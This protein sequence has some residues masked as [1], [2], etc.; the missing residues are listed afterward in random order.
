[1][2][3][4]GLGLPKISLKYQFPLLIKLLPAILEGLFLSY[5][6]PCPLS[7]GS[8]FRLHLGSPQGTW[9]PTDEDR[10]HSSVVTETQGFP[11]GHDKCPWFRNPRISK[12]LVR[13]GSHLVSAWP[14]GK[15]PIA[16]GSVQ[17]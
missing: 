14:A 9:K 5:V 4:W 16:C 6:S 11:P 10:Q 2:N 15:I 3:V 8:N 13:V 17:A 12:T 7:T 1:M